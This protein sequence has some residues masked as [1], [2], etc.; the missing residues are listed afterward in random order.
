MNNRIRQILKYSN[1][2]HHWKFKIITQKFRQKDLNT[3]SLT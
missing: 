3:N 1:I 2:R